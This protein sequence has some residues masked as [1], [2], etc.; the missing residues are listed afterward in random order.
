M[1]LFNKRKEE[2]DIEV[3]NKMLIRIFSVIVAI[4]SGFIFLITEDTTL[5]MVLVDQWTLLMLI[6]LFVQVVITILC[7]HKKEEKS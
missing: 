7:K 2:D 3:K 1:A 5:P 6:I 4:I